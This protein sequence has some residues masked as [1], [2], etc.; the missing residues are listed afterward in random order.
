MNSLALK[1]S[2]IDGKSEAPPGGEIVKEPK[3]GE[4]T[5]ILKEA[6]GRLLK[7]EMKSTPRADI[8]RAL[9]HTLNL[10]LTGIHTHSDPEEVE[11]FR[12]LNQEG[13]LTLRVNA[14][15]P[16]KGV[17]EYVAKGIK[18]RQGDAMVRVGYLKGFIDGTLGVRS[19][20]MFEPFSE[21]PGNTGLAQ[22]G[23]QEFYSLLEKADKHGFQIAIHAIGDKGVHWVLNGFEKAQQ[24]NGNR[25]MRH[26][27][28]HNTVVILSDLPRFK[29]LGV[30]AS[31]QPNITGPPAY[32][33]QR[34]G[35]ERAKRFDMWRSLLDHGAML[36]WGTDWPVSQ[37]DPMINLNKL[38]TRNPE[39]RL[40]MSEAIKFYTVG[41][42][43]ASFE[44]NLKGTLEPGKLADIVV[45]SKDLFAINPEEVL[46]TKVVYKI[47]GG[48]II[49][50]PGI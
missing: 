37:I 50:Q 30:I 28:E 19:A 9:K 13:R 26:R 40:T 23:E 43:Y 1:I 6:A 3:T 14:S 7:V 24:K 48:K 21:E 15:L 42:A 20:L 5:G 2:G 27:I 11:L 33:E 17:E 22:V 18:P 16:I 45:L 29:A 4:P 32:I 44:E 49:V 46:T 12:K 41:S 25:G 8:E 47:L 38:V 10:A 39:Q 34:L 31:M 36:C 35:P